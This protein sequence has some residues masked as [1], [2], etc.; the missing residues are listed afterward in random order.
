MASRPKQIEAA[1]KFL[2]GVV[3][4]SSFSEIREQQWR[5]VSKS[6]EKVAV[7]TPAQAAEWLAAFDGELWTAAQVA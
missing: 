4:S 2:R 3:A 1:Q 6:L 5:G 7:L